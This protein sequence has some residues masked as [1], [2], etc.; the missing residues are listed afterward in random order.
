MAARASVPTYTVTIG[1]G[2][3][4][5]GKSY[6][7]TKEVIRVI[8]EQRRPVYTNGP[9]RFRVVRQYLR[10][11]GGEELARLIFPLT[12]EHF[13]AF[14]ARQLKRAE[15]AFKLKEQ[16]RLL[17][18]PLPDSLLQRLWVEHAGPDVESAEPVIVQVPI[19]SADSLVAVAG[20]TFGL[21]MRAVR[22]LSKVEPNWIPQNAVIMIDEAQT[23]YPGQRVEGK[24]AAPGALTLLVSYLSMH[25]HHLHDLYFFTQNRM[26]IANVIRDLAKEWVVVRDRGNDVLFW[27]LR[28]RHLGIRLSAYVRYTAD[29]MG[30]SNPVPYED[31]SVSLASRRHRWVFRLYESFVHAG[32]LKNMRRKLR[33]VR[34]KQGVCEY[35]KGDVIVEPDPSGGYLVRRFGVDHFTPVE[36]VERGMGMFKRVGITAVLLMVGFGVGLGARD[37][38]PPTPA[39]VTAAAPVV[40]VDAAWYEGHKLGMFSRSGV[41]VDGRLCKVGGMI[42]EG[43]RAANLVGVEMRSKRALWLVDDELWLWATGKTPVSLGPASAVMERYRQ[44]R[45]D[46]GKSLGSVAK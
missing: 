2:L 39:V 35:D 43:K 45:D 25:R 46:A 9:L 20:G 7:L 15:F 44:A 5:S 40:A 6:W 32:G 10:N 41:V 26:N 8:V 14:L 11:R 34:R 42:N 29:Q 37:P 36:K 16:C 19:V 33:A 18:R 3:P 17:D 4:G 13:E 38:K 23:W 24:A 28:L 21:P 1:E 31:R 27:G 22:R 12:K 30:A